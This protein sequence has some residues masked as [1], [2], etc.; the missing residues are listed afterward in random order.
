VLLVLWSPSPILSLSP[1]SSWPSYHCQ[2]HY[3]P[4]TE[5]AYMHPHSIGCRLQILLDNLSPKIQFSTFC[6]EFKIVIVNTMTI[7]HSE[8][9]FWWAQWRYGLPCDI[10]QRYNFCHDIT[11]TTHYLPSAFWCLVAATL[12][13]SESNTKKQTW[14]HIVRWNWEYLACWK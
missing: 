13:V 4:L 1:S 11:P 2:H 7:R 3:Q 5:C 14:E 12:Q 6:I 8:N 9:T 10:D